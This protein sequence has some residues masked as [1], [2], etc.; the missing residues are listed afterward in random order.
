MVRWRLA[1]GTV[2]REAERGRD[3]EAGRDSW[4]GWPAGRGTC[5][6]GFRI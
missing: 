4:Y 6:P 2:G 5:T 3:R 1:T